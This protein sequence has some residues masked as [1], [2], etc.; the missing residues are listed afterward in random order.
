MTNWFKAPLSALLCA[1][2]VQ[3][4]LAAID[5]EG[6]VVGLQATVVTS[7]GVLIPGIVKT[8]AVFKIRLRVNTNGRVLALCVGPQS[9][10]PAGPCTKQIVSAS[11][12]QNGQLRDGLG[13]VDTSELLGKL[14]YLK[15]TTSGAP[16][17]DIVQYT[18]TIE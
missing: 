10:F 12:D 4:A 1:L 6:I 5:V 9:E 17:S 3:E 15:N 16:A 7:P 2:L 14:L 11:R 8:P 13:F 18:L